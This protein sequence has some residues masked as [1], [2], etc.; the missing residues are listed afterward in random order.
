MSA[1]PVVTLRLA[2]AAVLADE[3]LDPAEAR[4]L[5][6]LARELGA[7][8]SLAIELL[9]QAAHHSVQVH[10]LPRDPRD[11][12]ALFGELLRLVAADGKIHKGERRLLTR[13]ARKLGFDA[14]WLEEQLAQTPLGDA[15]TDS[16]ADQLLA[17]PFAYAL[18]ARYAPRTPMRREGLS[19][20]ARAWEIPPHAG[21]TPEIPD[22]LA[23]RALLVE[24][25][26]TAVRCGAPLAT[27][28]V[29]CEA[30]AGLLSE[31]GAF[32]AKALPW[33]GILVG[34]LGLAALGYWL[35]SLGQ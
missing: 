32:P 4:G 31:D 24:A 8:P 5:L 20:L 12:Q 26:V 29:L 34:L 3:V 17:P 16:T 27:W 22:P 23:R 11:R 25:M 33:R 13:I 21:P 35:G 1:D 7:P 14:A 30:S 2:C 28:A 10:A 19:A 6:R 9:G 18:L 15:T